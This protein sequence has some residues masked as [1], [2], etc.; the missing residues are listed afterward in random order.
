M[1]R[2]LLDTT[3]L[4]AAM[5][6]RGVNYKLIQLAR[7]SELFEPIITEVVVCEFIENCRKGMNGLI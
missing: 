1:D 2:V 5:I 3:V 6:T 7:S 4:C